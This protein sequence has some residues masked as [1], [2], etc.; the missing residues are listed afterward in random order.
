MIL[1]AEEFACLRLSLVESEYNRA[2]TEEAP[3]QV[4]LDVLAQ[5]PELR[6]WVAH[7]K[8]VPLEILQILAEDPDERV[9]CVVA[10][11][12]KLTHELRTKLS[13]DSDPS[14][15][16]RIAYNAKV[17]LHLL[18]QLAA[19]PEQFVRAAAKNALARHQ[20]AA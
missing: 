7:N 14:V 3:L 6:E 10:G 17:E 2:A 19:D 13:R 20:S 12:R 18:H 8:T 5:F 4:W 15:R 1:S 16:E 11:K 9:R